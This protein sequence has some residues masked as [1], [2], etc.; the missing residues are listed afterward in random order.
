MIALIIISY[1]L[2]GAKA[3]TPSPDMT[4]FCEFDPEIEWAYSDLQW[5]LEELCYVAFDDYFDAY[6]TNEEFQLEESLI[7]FPTHFYSMVEFSGIFPYDETATALAMM[8]EEIN[9]N[10]IPIVGEIR[11]GKV[12]MDF[13]ALAPHT[14]YTMYLFI[15]W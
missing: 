7:V 4:E 5:M 9:H 11:D 8:V 15:G 6:F 3:E 1:S 13:S 2:I 12:L 14:A 10:V